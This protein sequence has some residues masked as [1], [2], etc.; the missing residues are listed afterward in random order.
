MCLVGRPSW[1]PSRSCAASLALPALVE[2]AAFGRVLPLWQLPLLVSRVG[3]GNSICGMV[4]RTGC[5]RFR[6]LIRRWCGGWRARCRR[7]LLAAFWLCR[8][9]AFQRYFWEVRDVWHQRLRGKGTLGGCTGR[10]RRWCGLRGLLGVGQRRVDRECLFGGL[11]D[12]APHGQPLH[13]CHGASLSTTRDTVGNSHRHRLQQ[14]P[15]GRPARPSF[16]SQKPA[17]I[18][19]RSQ[20][21]VTVTRCRS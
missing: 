10:R 11:A 4:W 8:P 14:A 1:I 7:L 21:V 3:W 15:P 20:D 19:R 17:H 9:H 13:Q 16:A 18:L 6:A 5:L 12:F 2:P